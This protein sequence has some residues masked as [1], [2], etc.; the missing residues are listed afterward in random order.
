MRGGMEDGGKKNETELG[1]GELAERTGLSLRRG[2]GLSESEQ[3][4]RKEKR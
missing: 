2:G 3:G 1:G 4:G